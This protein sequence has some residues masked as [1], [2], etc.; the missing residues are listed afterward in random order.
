M[1]EQF[2]ISFVMPMFNERDNIEN[3]I[4]MIENISKVITDDYEIVI[5]D[6]AS[7]DGSGKIVQGIAERDEKIKSFILEKNTKFGGA[8]AKAVISATKDVIVYMDS[9]MP[10]SVEDIKMSI[11]LI[12]SVD[13]V[14]GY[15]KVKKGETFRRK[16]ISG[17]YNFIVRGCFGLHFK[18]INSGY[19]I[20]KREAIKDIKFHSKSPFVDVELFL[21]IM[22]NRGKIKQYPLVFLPRPGGKSYISRFPVILA[23]LRDIITVRIKSGRVKV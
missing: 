6:D 2:S 22:K 3:T 16:F 11:P 10:I 15:S 9:D 12:N 23:T 13:L 1:K 17:V 4:R 20:V 19:K 7:T 8:F 5:V 18:D 21:H 14:S